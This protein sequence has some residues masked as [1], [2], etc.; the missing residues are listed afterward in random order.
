MSDKTFSEVLE[1]ALQLPPADQAR[2]IGQLVAA[3]VTD[4]TEQST[5]ADFG[6]AAD[7]YGMHLG[8][9]DTAARSREILED[10]FAKH[11]SRRRSDESQEGSFG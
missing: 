9:T 6:L 8:V 3:L 7:Q 11:V 4:D 10:E 2:L 5:L 1:S